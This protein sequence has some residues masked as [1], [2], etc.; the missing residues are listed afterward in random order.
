MGR[1]GLVAHA[2][3]WRL[4]VEELAQILKNGEPSVMITQGKFQSVAKD[5]QKKID[6]IDHWLEYDVDSDHS[7][8]LLL[9]QSPSTEPIVARRYW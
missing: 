6:F 7:F 2:L 4:G 1:V 5:L 9:D 8:D 3:N